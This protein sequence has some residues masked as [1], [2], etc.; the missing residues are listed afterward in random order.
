MPRRD[1]K[2]TGTEHPAAWRAVR[3]VLMAQ[4]ARAAGG[5][6]SVG[7]GGV[8]LVHLGGS[9]CVCRN[10]RLSQAAGGG[11]KRVARTGQRRRRTVRIVKDDPC[12]L[13]VMKRG[14]L[15]AEH[16]EAC[17]ADDQVWV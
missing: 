1:V 17:Q 16:F 13:Q 8:L 10:G 3:Q 11:R 9:R 4:I 12:V 2:Q 7:G 5:V 15:D 14:G 6:I